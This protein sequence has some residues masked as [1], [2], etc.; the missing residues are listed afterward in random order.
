MRLENPVTV[1]KGVGEALTSRLA[2]LGVE[3]VQDLLYFFPR[4]YDDFSQII[5]IEKLQPGKVTLQAKLETITG[6]YI[7]RRL[8][9]TEAVLADKTG[10]VR[11]VWFNQPYRV[12]QLKP[13]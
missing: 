7:K 2:M 13:D 6:R 1:V 3:T 9:I 5:P 11:A 4:K 8:H 12:E 10:K